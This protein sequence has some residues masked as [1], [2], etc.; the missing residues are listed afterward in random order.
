MRREPSD[1]AFPV[2]DRSEHMSQDLGLTRLEYFMARAPAVP[3]WYDSN[4]P[5]ASVRFF[6]WPLHYAHIMTRKADEVL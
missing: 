6:N 1:P 2:S 3:D 5:D 4:Q